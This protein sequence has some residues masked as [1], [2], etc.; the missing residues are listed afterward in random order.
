MAAE[1]VTLGVWFHLRSIPPGSRLRRWAFERLCI[2]NTALFSGFAGYQ[3]K[4]WMVDP[5]TADYAGLYTWRGADEATAYGEYVTALL[6]PVSAPG[7]VGFQLLPGEVDDY[8][9]LPVGAHR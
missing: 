4:L 1:P 7:S 8:L 3:L 2:L 9:M 5:R 6:A